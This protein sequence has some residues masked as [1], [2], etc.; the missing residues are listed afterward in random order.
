MSEDNYIKDLYRELAIL[1]ESN[2]NRHDILKIVQDIENAGYID[3]VVAISALVT[4]E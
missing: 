3:G 2:K 1:L 4:E